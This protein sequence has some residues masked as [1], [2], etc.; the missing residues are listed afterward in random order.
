MGSKGG[1][2]FNYPIGGYYKMTQALKHRF[3]LR[4]LKS[5]WLA[6]NMV[7]GSIGY[8]LL[9]PMK[10]LLPYLIF[11][12]LFFTFVSIDLRD[13]RWHRWFTV[14]LIIQW[15]GGWLLYNLILTILCH[16][17][18]TVSPYPTTIAQGVAICIMMPTASA[19]PIVCRKIGGD[20]Y[21][22][23]SFMV[24]SNII[25][26]FLLPAFFAMANPTANLS[27][28][29]TML[30]ILKRTCT[31]LLA[32][33]LLAF[34]IR[35][36]KHFFSFVLPIKST[37]TSRLMAIKSNLPLYL[38]GGTVTILS[39]DIMRTL[40]EGEYSMALVIWLSLFSLMTCLFQFTVGWL[41][42]K[43]YG[44]GQPAIK[45]AVGQAFGQKNTTF[46]IWLSQ[47][48]LTPLAFFAPATYMIWQNIIN[49][50]K[51]ATFQQ[52]LPVPLLIPLFFLLATS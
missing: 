28:L 39:A 42:G 6:I 38:W 3:D 22:T 1:D 15:C 49:N 52:N 45:V 13:L 50:R 20:V 41:V 44:H 25:T 14:I 32:P 9:C 47:I 37:T 34:V 51:I 36:G 23:T 7:I 18:P 31:V 24:I 19:A 48:Y 35:E 29:S 2:K 30:L 43:R 8:K 10:F 26:A 12:M 33:L 21:S 17:S 16:F 40:I 27:F 4:L 46:G 11:G 5:N